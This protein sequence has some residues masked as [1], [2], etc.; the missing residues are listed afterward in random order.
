MLRHSPIHTQHSHAHTHARTHTYKHTHT[1]AHSILQ[2]QLT[3][4][5]TEL[6][7]TLSELNQVKT[8]LSK[9]V[10]EAEKARY[11]WESEVRSKSK[12]NQEVLKLERTQL[13]KNELLNAVNVCFY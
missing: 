7:A 11:L 4:Q 8:A 1:Q 5:Q 3:E 6:K 12:L 13:D 10:K 9:A 2:K